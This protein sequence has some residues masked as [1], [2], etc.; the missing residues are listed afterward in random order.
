MDAAEHAVQHVE[1]LTIDTKAHPQHH[2]PACAVGKQ[3]CNPFPPSSSCALCACVPGTGGVVYYLM[4][5]NDLTCW[6]WLKLLTNKHKDTILEAFKEYKAMTEANTLLAS[7]SQP[8]MTRELS[9]LGTGLQHGTRSMA[10][11]CIPSTEWEL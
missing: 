9:S 5:T 8:K 10:H 7:W 1:G 4:I 11:V 6:H 3:H 2:C